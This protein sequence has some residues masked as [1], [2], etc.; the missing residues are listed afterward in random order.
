MPHVEDHQ[1]CHT[2]KTTKCATRRANGV[3]PL[4]VTIILLIFVMGYD[5][6]LCVVGKRIGPVSTLWLKTPGS[7]TCCR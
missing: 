7:R 5:C 3:D 2:P 4:D 1:V 6:A